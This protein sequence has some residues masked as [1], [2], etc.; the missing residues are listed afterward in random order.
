MITATKSIVF[1]VANQGVVAEIPK[2]GD[3]QE[4]INSGFVLLAAGV[5]MIGGAG[6]SHKDSIS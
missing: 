2:K 3:K 4:G 6:A 5:V 1:G